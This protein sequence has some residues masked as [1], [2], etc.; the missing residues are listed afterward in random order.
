M[1]H[2]SL[3]FAGTNTLQFVSVLNGTC[4]SHHFEPLDKT[5]LITLTRTAS[6]I[7]LLT[8]Q[9]CAE[10]AQTLFGQIDQPITIEIK[11]VPNN[12]STTSQ[13]EDFF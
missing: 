7:E 2:F 6:Q 4:K 9:I 13:P 11:S 3:S 10:G 1:Q 5:F 12:L 8:T